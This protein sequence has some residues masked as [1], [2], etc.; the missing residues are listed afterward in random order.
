MTLP[1]LLTRVIGIA[2]VLSAVDAVS[3]RALHASV[4]PSAALL[5]GAPAWVAFRLAR[6]GR[7]VALQ[8]TVVPRLPVTRWRSLCSTHRDRR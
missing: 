1:K 4:N 6:Y 5:L 8:A 7:Y 3:G 2:V